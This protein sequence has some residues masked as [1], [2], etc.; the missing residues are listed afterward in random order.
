MLSGSARLRGVVG[1]Y[2]ARSC[3][4]LLGKAVA[5]TVISQVDVADATLCYGD[6]NA[7]EMT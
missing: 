7:I 5:V 6:W 3:M 1:I 4:G 2:G